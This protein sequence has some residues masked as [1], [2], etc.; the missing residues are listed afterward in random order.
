ML[1]KFTQD[2][3]L[4]SLITFIVYFGLELVAEGLVSNYFDLHILLGMII[5]SGAV[6]SMAGGTFKL[7]SK[8][9]Y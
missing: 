3:F 1:R 6:N 7:P 5:V 9:K 2:I 4:I 8:D